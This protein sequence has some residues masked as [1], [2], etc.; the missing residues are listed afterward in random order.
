MTADEFRHLAL[1]LPE[2]SEQAHMNHPDFRVRNRVFA[3]LGYPDDDW[4]MVKLT[5]EQQAIFVRS[6]PAVFQAV[7]GGWGR[8]GCTKRL[9]ADCVGGQRPASPGCS[10]AQHRAKATRAALRGRV[11]ECNGPVSGPSPTPGG[12]LP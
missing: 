1:S 11:G 5:A 8:R 2:A 12:N 4:G 7:K 10:M 6:E 9:P 3:T